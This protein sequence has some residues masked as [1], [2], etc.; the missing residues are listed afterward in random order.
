MEHTKVIIINEALTLFSTKG[1]DGVSMRDIAKEVGI[2]A[3]SIY[4]HFSSKEEIF[5]SIIDEMSKRYHEM[6]MKSQAPQVLEDALDVYV[7]MT[8]DALVN[9]ARHLLTFMLKDDFTVKF[10][11]LLTVEQ[12]RS[13]KASIAY[14]NFF[15]NGALSFETTL[16]HEMMKKGVFITCNPEIMAYHF[17]GPIFLMINQFSG[18]TYDEDVVMTLVGEHV[19]QFSSIYVKHLRTSN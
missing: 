2:Q 11:K 7:N 18:M 8:T 13:E 4:N 10:R 12:Y 3:P 17:Y 14:Q 9:I 15:I 16:F 6:A 19:K 5:N 1:Y